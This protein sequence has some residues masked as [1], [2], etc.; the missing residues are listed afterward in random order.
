[1]EREQPDQVAQ[2]WAYADGAGEIGLIASVTQPFC[3][4]CS[5]ARLSADGVLYTCLFA[6]EGLDLRTP[7]RTGASEEQLLALVRT[8]WQ[9]R[10]DR[11]S[12]L[13]GQLAG[14]PVRVEMNRLGG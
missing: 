8:C 12:E 6:S 13:R 9:A 10:S 14:I 4:D 11:Y 5:R 2:R 3:G 7:L 1:L